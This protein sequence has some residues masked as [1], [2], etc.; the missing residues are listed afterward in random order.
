MKNEFKCENKKK[1]YFHSDGIGLNIDLDKN[2]E[3]TLSRACNVVTFTFDYHGSKKYISINFPDERKA[4][5]YFY[6]MKLYLS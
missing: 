1:G 2:V 3:I 6:F 5:E 4:S